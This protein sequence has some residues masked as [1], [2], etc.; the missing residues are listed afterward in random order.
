M[1]K[2]NKA[3]KIALEYFLMIVFVG[4][5]FFILTS[6]GFVFAEHIVNL[7]DG[8]VNITINE[9]ISSLINITINNTDA[10]VDANITEVNITLPSSF[11]FTNESN[12]SVIV[13]RISGC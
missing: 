13:W 2:I 7:T 9:D 1:V 6:S 8:T 12:G 10:G 4:A 11:I 3:S 5:F